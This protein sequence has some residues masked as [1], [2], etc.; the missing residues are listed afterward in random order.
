MIISILT[1]NGFK[2]PESVQRPQMLVCFSQ[3]N[4]C[5]HLHGELFS[6]KHIVKISDNTSAGK[7]HLIKGHKCRTSSGK[8]CLE[9]WAPLSYFSFCKSP[10]YPLTIS[11]YIF[12]M[13]KNANPIECL[14]PN[15]SQLIKWISVKQC[16]LNDMGITTSRAELNDGKIRSKPSENCHFTYRIPFTMWRVWKSLSRPITSSFLKTLTFAHWLYDHLSKVEMQAAPWLFK[17]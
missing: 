2:T 4:I 13:P 15:Q 3:R 10:G 5:C 12:C 6:S 1:G 9:F 17:S 11:G 14:N 8:H 7:V 16:D